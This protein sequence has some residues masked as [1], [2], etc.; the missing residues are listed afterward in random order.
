MRVLHCLNIRMQ[1][2]RAQGRHVAIVGDFNIAPTPLDHCSPAPDFAARCDRQWLSAL[3][4]PPHTWHPVATGA[5]A[6]Q[7][8]CVATASSQAARSCGCAICRHLHACV[9]SEAVGLAAGWESSQDSHS[10]NARGGPQT[11]WPSREPQGAGAWPG[12]SDEGHSGEGMRDNDARQEGGL[13]CGGFADTFRWFHKERQSAFTCW[14]VATGARSNNMGTRIDLVLTADP[15]APGPLVPPAGG[16]TSH[17]TEGAQEAATKVELACSAPSNAAVALRC[18][19][20]D[21]AISPV[22]SAARQPPSDSKGKPSGQPNSGHP[23]WTWR[24]AAVAADIMPEFGGSDHAPAWLIV[25]TDRMAGFT[26]GSQGRMRL[27][28]SSA[29]LFTGG[30]QTSL[31]SLW[32]GAR[33]WPLAVTPVSVCAISVS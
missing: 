27:P 17:G 3:L 24:G 16:A 21:P 26:G 30:T 6:R 9:A 14:N 22:P 7:T 19:L 33:L 31:A 8:S 1:R 18:S 28:Q 10:T 2:L 25:A 29:N 15:A 11:G 13:P 20:E 32:R 4:S 23:C 5:T 12:G